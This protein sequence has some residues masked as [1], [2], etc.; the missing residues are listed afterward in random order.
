MT[1]QTIIDIL[2][3]KITELSQLTNLAF[4]SGNLEEYDKIERELI[5]TEKTLKEL[6][7]NR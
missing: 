1:I 4:Q 2:E 6:Y 5:E 7:A 3:K